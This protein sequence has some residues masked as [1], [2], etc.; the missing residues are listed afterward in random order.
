MRR[1]FPVL[2]AA[3]ALAAFLPALNGGFVGWDD[4]AYLLDNAAFRGLGWTQLRWMATTGYMGLYQPLTWLSFGCDYRL[5]G[6][7]P[8]GYHLANLLLHALAAVLFYGVCARLLKA[9]GVKE[10]EERVWAAVAGALF[11]AV[12][13]LRVESVAW[14]TERKD[15]LSGVFFIGAVLAYLAAV[16]EGRRSRR[17]LAGSVFLF[18]LSLGAK[19]AGLMLP[20]ALIIIDVYPLGRLP[21]DPR[22]W[23]ER[24]WRPVWV[25]KLPFTAA[26]AALAAANWAAMRTAGDLHGLVE[27]GAAWRLG[28]ALYGLLF[29]P[30]KLLWPAGLLPYYPPRPWFGAWGPQVPA[31][32]L[33]ACAIAAAVW[34]LGRR[35]PA[36][37]AALLFYV[38]MLAPVSGLVQHGLA[39]SACDRYSYLPSLGF[40]A[41]FAGAVAAACKRRPRAAR[42]AA[43]ALLAVLGAL[44]WRQSGFWHDSETLWRR[45]LSSEPGCALA[46]GNLGVAQAEAGRFEAAA[47]LLERAVAA[48]ETLLP[49]LQSLGSVARRLGRLEEAEGALRRALAL[50]PSAARVQAELGELLAEGGND[51][52][53]EALTL[54]QDALA[55]GEE[56]ARD[57]L[58][59][60]L[61]RLGRRDEARAQYEAALRIA[62]G[63]GVAHN[64]LGLLLAQGGDEKAAEAH[65]RLALRDPA[66]RSLAHYNWGNSLSARG[67][68]DRAERHYAEALRL[69]PN[70]AKAQLNW[71]NGLARRGQFAQAAAHYRAALKSAPNFKEARENLAAALRRLGR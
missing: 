62:S 19:L 10:E 35:R 1:L 58:A 11:F 70:F 36:V 31:L 5:W 7:D 68:E 63:D 41:L 15:V 21:G 25:E 6:L 42:A 26:A 59:G 30:I 65:Y 37:L 53:P 8:A 52:L 33:L 50:Q 17:W 57:D 34:A 45:M 27:R 2:V 23:L 39:Y 12:H 20:V 47:A 46:L 13:P 38:V 71:G 22:R 3:A 24:R 18:T 43:G 64:N 32:A 56:R 61:A 16:G 49:A 67:L 4:N 54:L 66:A 29:Y 60:V 55:G 44:S 40:C 9:A 51:S 69:S 14:V 28:Q 48:D